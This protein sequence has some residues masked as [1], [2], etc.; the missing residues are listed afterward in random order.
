MTRQGVIGRGLLAVALLAAGVAAGCGSSDESKIK[1]NDVDRAFAAM[2][3]PHHEAAVEM[4]QIAQDRARRPQ[5]RTLAGNIIRSQTTEINQLNELGKAA[6][7]KAKDMG[8]MEHGSGGMSKEHGSA[9]G[10]SEEEMGMKGMEEDIAMLRK[11]KPFER[12]FIDMM[13]PHHQSAI[14]MARAEL[15]K[16]QDPKLKA[17]AQQI[18]AA[19]SKEITE[20]NSWRTDWY[21]KPSPTGGI[22]RDGAKQG[23]SSGGGSGGHSG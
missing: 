13:V 6:G 5:V 22:P 18:I 15:A 8:G 11:A 19:Q 7:N 23:H 3:V 17:L 2:M 21:G 10:L 20:M 4:A 9:L 1:A 12:E 16:G 14:I